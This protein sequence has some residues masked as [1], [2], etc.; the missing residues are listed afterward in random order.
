MEI[1]RFRGSHCPTAM[2]RRRHPR[3]RG[4]LR[5]LSELTCKAAPCS[6]NTLPNEI[7]LDII[8]HLKIKGK[9]PNEQ[10]LDHDSA[11]ELASVART[12]RQ[13]YRLAMPMLWE[14]IILRPNIEWPKGIL[15]YPA[16]GSR[17][18]LFYVRNLSIGVYC[19]PNEG[20]DEDPPY[21]TKKGFYR[22]SRQL[23]T[24]LKVLRDARSL[25]SIRLFLGVYEP[26]NY[27]AE[28]TGIIEALN[29]TAF[30]ILRHVAKMKIREFEFYPGPST[31]R[32]EDITFIIEGKIDTL[33]II[34]P[35]RHWAS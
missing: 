8:G 17:R 26:N 16:S 10:E 12:C 19:E 29:R 4:I 11:C 15:Q 23:S 24:S 28:F 1:R 22:I 5:I 13:F 6:I 35:L 2:V 33:S 21:P 27:P 7:L 30:E 25:H 14:S 20:V 3:R 18:A 32:I 9:V 34:S 31:A